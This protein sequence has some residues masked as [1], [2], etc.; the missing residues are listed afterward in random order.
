MVEFYLP[1]LS[2]A[3]L[4]WLLEWTGRALQGKRRVTL[5]K[6]TKWLRGIVATEMDRRQSEDLLETDMPWIPLQDW[7]P[8]QIGHALL[9]LFCLSRETDSQPIGEFC[10]AILDVVVAANFHHTER[11]TDTESRRESRVKL[12]DIHPNKPDQPD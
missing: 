1:R 5:V 3:D 6:F 8:K 4:L 2:A 10:D 7:S 12:T 11:F 9:V